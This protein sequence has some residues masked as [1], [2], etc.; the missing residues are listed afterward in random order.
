MGSE[1]TQI[2]Q[3]EDRAARIVVAECFM[4][5]SAS[6]REAYESMHE[7]VQPAA[8]V[9]HAHGVT[10]LGRGLCSCTVL[11]LEVCGVIRG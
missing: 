7:L 3:G 10:V 11:K 5:A 1:A 9:R 8:A 4:T 6:L 2:A